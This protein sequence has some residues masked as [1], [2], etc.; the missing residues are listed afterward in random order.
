MHLTPRRMV[1]SAL[2][3]Y[4]RPYSALM[5]ATLIAFAHFSVAS[6]RI[7][8][9]NPIVSLAWP[10]EITAPSRHPSPPILNVALWQV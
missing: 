10:D 7:G 6:T 8:N 9:L 1:V 5:P 4:N 3:P 2:A